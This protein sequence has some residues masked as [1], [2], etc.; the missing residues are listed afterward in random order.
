MMGQPLSDLKA[1]IV[2][3]T[4]GVL[5]LAQQ[6]I[7]TAMFQGPCIRCARCVD[8]CP[9]G[10]IP[11]ELALAIRSEDMDQATKFGL[12]DCVGCGSCAYVC[13]SNIPLVQYFNYAKGKITQTQRADH[14]QKEI[15]RLAEARS[16]RM[17][18]IKRAKREAMA[19]RKAERANRK[20]TDPVS[21]SKPENKQE[22]KKASA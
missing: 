3:G 22:T 12:M 9:C 20:S 7:P 8:A 17:E 15:K 11:L 14:K 2:K 6:E 16:E 5:A 21:A 13:P 4:N 1:P 18:R 19:K 10:L